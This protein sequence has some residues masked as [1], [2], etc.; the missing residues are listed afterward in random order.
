MSDDGSGAG[1]ERTGVV[2]RVPRRWLNLGGFLV[3]LG[4]LA[5]AYYLQT[6]RGLQP[7]PLCIMQR[8]AF[9]GLGLVFLLAA[10]H[11]PRRWGRYVYAVLLLL[12]A[13]GGAGVA[14]RHVYLQHLPPDMVPACGPGLGYILQNFSPGR[15]IP[16]ILR[17]S[18]ECAAIHWRFLGLTIPGWSLV[19]FVL[20]GITGV[21][22]NALPEP[23]R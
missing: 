3:C 5:Y 11:N 4:L 22:R 13:G 9:M 23:A 15:A 18:G 7:C 16:L 17:G 21:V 8:V 12:I 2:R 14:I 6:V 10:V 1:P 20:L 19:M